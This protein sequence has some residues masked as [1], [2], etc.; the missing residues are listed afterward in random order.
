M[1]IFL[2]TA[3]VPSIA[4]WA[5]KMVI[6]GVTT[7]PTLLSKEQGDPKS[8]LQKICA[9]LP[10]GVVS[11]EVTEQEP[12]KVYQ[13]AIELAAFAENVVVKIPCHVRYYEVIA[14]LVEKNIPLNITLVFS[15]LQGLMMCKLGVDYIS[16]FM[17]RLDDSGESGIEVVR[18]M[19][20]MIHTYDFATE[21]IVASVRSREHFR[22]AIEVGSHAITVPPA[23]LE[24]AVQHPLTDQGI[25]KFLNDW[26]KLGVTQF[27]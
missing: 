25:E 24:E 3:H 17:G 7:N 19:C 27:P 13:Q 4:I 9:L 15:V 8:I 26:K 18:E 23:I 1:K 2:D 12:K 21:V 14:M 6:D 5:G 22:Q 10:D 11:V 16:P 20:D